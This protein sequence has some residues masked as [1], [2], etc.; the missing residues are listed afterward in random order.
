[1]ILD[2][3]KDGSATVLAAAAL[4]ALLP[5]LGPAEAAGTTAHE[6]K[7]RVRQ[8]PLRLDEPA[9]ALP[10]EQGVVAFTA[11]LKGGS[12]QQLLS[13]SGVTAAEAKSAAAL[14]ST[15]LGGQVPAGSRL[16]MTLG[17]KLSG[18]GQ[19]RRLDKLVISAG[20]FVD[21]IVEAR[22]G[23]LEVSSKSRLA[24][25]EPRRF[26]GTAGTQPFWS[27]RRAGVPAEAA[28]EYLQVLA[29]RMRLADVEG[30]ARF[31][32]VVERW[33]DLDGREQLG[34]LV[35]AG[36][37][38]ETGSIDLVR[39]NVDGRAAWIDPA[40]PVQQA[41][42]FAAPAAGR[43]TSA[44][45]TRVHPILRFARF[46][47]GID[48]GAAWGAPVHAVADG[49]VTGAGWHG[50]YGRQV[51]I[52]HAGSVETGYAHLSQ[53]MIEPGVRVRRGQVIGLVGSSGFSTGPHLH[54]NV[55]RNGQPINPLTYRQKLT[56]PLEQLDVAALR[57]R[58]DQLRA[59]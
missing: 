35:Y 49:V 57:I 25:A 15:A 38:Q 16:T 52:A 2:V 40:R 28:A 26:Q 22:N 20:Q 55:R 54:F 31:D 4:L 23:A 12:L 58:L 24:A 36:L 47:D 7:A 45:G 5:S 48:I 43:V 27:L 37:K 56:R 41:E 21:V 33:R 59:I 42:V 34:S 10:R 29:S 32:L 18:S 9:P 8:V 3:L 46:H 17:D 13:D 1:V 19:G 14:A 39:W 51:R 50:G 11:T 6:N 44:F 30:A 53:V